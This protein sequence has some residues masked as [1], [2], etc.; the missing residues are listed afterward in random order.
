MVNQFDLLLVVH[1]LGGQELVVLVVLGDLSIVPS[2]S[3][4]HVLAQ[5]P[6]RRLDHEP[7]DDQGNYN[8]Q[9]QEQLHLSPIGHSPTHSAQVDE[10][11]AKVDGPEAGDKVPEAHWS[12]LDDQCIRDCLH[13]LH[14]EALAQSQ[15]HKDVNVV[16]CEVDGD[17]KDDLANDACNDHLLAAERVTERAQDQSSKGDADE[18]T[19]AGEGT[20]EAFLA[21][22]SI[23]AGYRYR[24]VGVEGAE[25]GIQ[26]HARGVGVCQVGDVGHSVVVL[27]MV[28]LL[29]EKGRV[30]SG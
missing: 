23:L 5:H 28:V 30:E 14:E 3:V 8:G 6:K 17:S 25:R 29:G 24:I 12:V 7:T 21:H 19:S 1:L 15:T 4:Q 2:G 13:A 16:G 18:V 10:A 11:Q 9:L 27:I 22:Q 26:A 20:Q